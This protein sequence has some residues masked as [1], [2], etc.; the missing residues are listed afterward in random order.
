MGYIDLIRSY[1]KDHNL[2]SPKA[3]LDIGCSVGVSTH[4]LVDTFPGAEVSGLDLS[5]HFL[6]VAKY[7]DA[8]RPGP[9]VGSVGAMRHLNRSAAA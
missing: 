4:W 2:P 9:K 6:A 7:R 1:L 8:R 5:P 3:I